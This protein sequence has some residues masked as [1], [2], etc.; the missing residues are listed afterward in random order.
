MVLTNVEGFSQIKNL[1]DFRKSCLLVKEKPELK[2]HSAY[3][4]TEGS[5]AGNLTL[6]FNSKPPKWFFS[7]LMTTGN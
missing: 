4:W 2:V 3:W 6:Q 7:G 1:F 5:T